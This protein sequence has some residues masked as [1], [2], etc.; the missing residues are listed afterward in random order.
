MA[1]EYQM[2]YVRLGNTGLKVSRICLGC[3]TYGD[4]QW[5]PWVL[6]EEQ[7][8]PIF[9]KAFEMGINFYDTADMYSIGVSEEVL[10]RAIKKYFPKREDVVIASKCYFPQGPGPN[11]KGLS[12]KHI[13]HAVEDSLRHL[14]TDYIDLYQIHRWDYETP[15][16]ETMEALHDLVKS[17]KVRYIGASSMYAW[18]FMKA[19]HYA[20]MKGLTKFVTMQNH[21]NLIYREEEREMI[22][23]CKS[24]GIGL[25][26]W[27]PLARGFLCGKRD[28]SRKGE[29]LRSQTDTISDNL[30]TDPNDFD[31]VDRVE[32]LAKQKGK[33]MAQVSLAWLFNKPEIT[34]PIIGAS[35]ISHLEDAYQAMQ[36]QLT[37]EEIK[38]IEE[39]YKP[40]KISGHQ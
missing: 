36:I 3:M 29:T 27:S 10:G 32:Q 35:K 40:H 39:V 37:P 7:A 14:G 17:G 26:P 11:N 22:P 18:Q 15:I 12:R 9:Q 31:V 34:A 16:E 1:S 28:Q 20:E 19:Q 5:R 4:P 23:Y 25:L 24:A 33:S 13:M 38:S 2:Q 6:N 8:A 21:Y 30:Y